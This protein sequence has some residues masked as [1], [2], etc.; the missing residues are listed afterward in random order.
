MVPADDKVTLELAVACGSHVS[1]DDTEEDDAEHTT[2]HDHFS[3]DDT[4]EDDEQH[5]HRHGHLHRQV[6]GGFM[7]VAEE[8]TYAKLSV[9]KF[10]RLTPQKVVAGV[11]LEYPISSAIPLDTFRILIEKMAC[12]TIRFPG[13]KVERDAIGVDIE[14]LDHALLREF[15]EGVSIHIAPNSSTLINHRSEFGEGFEMTTFLVDNYIGQVEPMEYNRTG[16]TLEWWTVKA[17]LDN[18]DST[19]AT[20]ETLL[21]LLNDILTMPYEMTRQSRTMSTR[22][23]ERQK[24]VHK[25]KGYIH[26]K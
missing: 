18:T 2:K 14:S 4:E 3:G 5:K 6:S 22:A 10:I 11:V 7:D 23:F 17:L 8:D 12:G 13:G 24:Q 1:G 21:I 20:K 9:P 15:E 19:M 25:Y 16:A 26:L